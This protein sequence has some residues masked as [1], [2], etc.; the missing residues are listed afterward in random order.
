MSQ[1]SVQCDG[2]SQI[3]TLLAKIGEDIRNL[4]PLLDHRSAMQASAPILASAMAELS[5]SLGLFVSQQE[6]DLR[7]D[8]ARFNEVIRSYQRADT[9][10]VDSATRI[11]RHPVTGPA[12]P[13]LNPASN[14]PR[15]N[16]PR[17]T[18]PRATT[19]PAA[20]RTPARTTPPAGTQTGPR[21]APTPGAGTRQ[22][23][24]ATA[25][26]ALRARG[27]RVDGFNAESA[28]HRRNNPNSEH[29]SG[30]ALDWHV[31]GDA[32]L[33]EAMQIPGVRYVIH[34]RRIYFARDGFQP[35]PYEGRFPRGGTKLPHTDHIHVNF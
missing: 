13:T 6:T 12:S 28:E 19:P 27:E 5:S 1:F 3:P 26:Q 16:T 7:S 24:A 22:E 29:G 15:A 35:R 9:A 2:L 17:A 23:N 14:T 4:Q 11:L 25:Y 20:N 18:T 8:A 34:D 31:R 21:P 10:V 32:R 33:R 30:L